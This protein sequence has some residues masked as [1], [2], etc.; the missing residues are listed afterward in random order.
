VGV[1]RI[2][3][4]FEARGLIPLGAEPPSLAAATVVGRV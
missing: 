4:S 3:R 2:Y 1:G